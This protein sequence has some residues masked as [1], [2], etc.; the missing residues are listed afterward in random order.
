MP[1]CISHEPS[2]GKPIS[3][4]RRPDEFGETSSK[5]E[6]TMLPFPGHVPFGLRVFSSITLIVPTY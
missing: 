5:L 4:Q 6:A 3:I 1:L 2:Q